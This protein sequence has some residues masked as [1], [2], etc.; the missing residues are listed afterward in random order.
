MF[1]LRLRGYRDPETLREVYAR[2]AVLFGQ[3]SH[4][5]MF[6]VRENIAKDR[7]VTRGLRCK[8]T[9]AF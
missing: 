2:A 7:M 4:K 9:K 6:H 1:G 8:N 5:I 3:S